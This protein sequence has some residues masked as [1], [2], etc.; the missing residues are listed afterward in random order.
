MKTINVLLVLLIIFITSCEEELNTVNEINVSQGTYV[1]VVHVNWEPVP[2][3]AYYNIE[4]KGPDGEWIG[5]GTVTNPPFDDYGYGLPD[6]KLVEGVKYRYRISSGSG[7]IE[8]SPYSEPSEEGW[9][10]ELQAI[11]MQAIR[12]NEG[13]IIVSWIDTNQNQLNK[14]NLLSCRYIIKRRYDGETEFTDLHTTDYISTPQNMSYTDANVANDKKAFY[15]IEGWYN[16]EY[17]NLDH[18]NF[19]GHWIKDY[20]EVQ[21][22]GGTVQVNYTITQLGDIQRA[23]DGYG[24][25]R[26]KNINGEMFAA[27]IPKPVYGPPI[28]FKLNGTTWQNLSNNYPD[29]LQKN[30]EKVSICGD[31][32]NVWVGGIA[33][34]AYVYAFN[35]S[36]SGNLAAKNFGL[37]DNL[38]LPKIPDNLCLEY[39]ESNLYAL[40]AHDDKLEVFSYAQNSSWNSE[41]IIENS[42]GI[43]D[44]GFKVFNGKLYTYYH[45]FNSENNS[46]LKIKHL[47][48]SSWQTDFDVAYDNIMNVSVSVDNSGVIYF[49][50][51]SQEPATWKG[52]VFKVT[53][54]STAQE[55]VSSSNTWLTYPQDIDYDDNGNPMVLYYKIISQTNAEFRLA[56]Y[57]N[58]EWKDVAGDFSNHIGPSDIESNN[59]LYFVYGDGND[60]VNSYPTILKA[61]KLNH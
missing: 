22:S 16:Y 27:T 30:F 2:E 3:A 23:N 14:T 39:F 13:S 19:S 21:E 6:N 37:V 1:G 20:S 40:I 60:L 59:G 41:G 53:S 57:E 43:F 7:D 36:W 34:S 56:V 54:T 24:F 32:T 11:E 55:L 38:G 5:A 4:R 28:I 44:L 26:L 18:G 17:K 45:V 12:N 9:I 35:S 25:V 47:E 31:G 49:T 50:S 10:Y 29:G 61:I 48:G 51:D 33:D 42:S 52:N 15:T 46:T 58:N 8:D